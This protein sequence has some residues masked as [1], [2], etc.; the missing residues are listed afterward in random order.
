MIANE[1]RGLQNVI[2][3]EQEKHE[4]LSSVE[5]RNN[6]EMQYLQQQMTIVFGWGF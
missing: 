6:K 1:I 2:R 4:K 5:E 3:E